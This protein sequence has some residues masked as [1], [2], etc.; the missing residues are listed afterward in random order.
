MKRIWQHPDE[1]TTGKRYWRSLNQLAERPG[2]LEARVRE[3]PDGVEALKDE[4]EAETSRRNF[5]KLMGAS[6]ALAGL[7]ACRRPEFA[8]KP[9]A[10][11]P[12]WVIPGKVLFYAT[13]MPRA[14]SGTP[15]VVHTFEGR[16]T[17]L[18]GN[19]LHPDSNGG[20]DIQAQAS[21][22]NL[23]DPNRAQSFQKAG[24]KADREEFYKFLDAKK[25]EL[26]AKQGG[27][28]A[29]L[30]DEAVT[31]T[32]QRLLGE[33][34]KKHPQ[35]KIYR[36]ETFG[37][38]NVRVAY[39]TAF[40]AGAAP[41]YDLSKADRVFSLD[42]DF[43]GQ[44]RIGN[45]ATGQFMVRRKADAPEDGPKMNRLYVAEGRFTVTGGMADHR[46]RVHTSQ[47]LKAA[48]RLGIAVAELT[49][50]AG[51]KA[52]AEAVKLAGSYQ[53]HAR[54]DKADF[55]SAFF[56]EAAK[57]LVEKKGAS[58]VLAGSQQDA[59]VHLLAIAINQA[60]GAFGTVIQ[61]RQTGSLVAGTLDELAASAA[62]KQIDTL[63]VIG[64]TDPVF[65]A[66]PDIV[67]G[68]L[69]AALKAVPNVIV[70]TTRPKTITAAS[71]SWVVPATHYLEQWGDTRGSEGSLAVVQ[72]MIAPLYSGVLSDVEL[73]LAVLS[74]APL[75]GQPAPAPSGPG[76]P[77][78]TGFAFK[79]VRATFDAIVKDPSESKWN[80]ALRDGFAAGSAYPSASAAAAS[81]QAIGAALAQAK[82]VDIGEGLEITFVPC[83]KIHDGRYINNGWL[84]EAPDSM[85][86][87]TWDN[88]AIVSVKTGKAL[89]I[90][91]FTEDSA[92]V[93]SVEVNGLKRYYPVLMIPGHADNSVTIATGYGQASAGRVGKGTGFDAYALRSAATPY[94]AM[95]A[96]TAV[97][98]I[99]E[100][101]SGS[102]AMKGI[103]GREEIP[104]VYPLG[105]TEEHHTMYGRALVREGTVED[106]QKDKDFVMQQGTD[107]HLHGDRE[108]KNAE[109]SYSFYKPA[110]GNDENGK[111]IELLNDT[112]HQWGMVIDLNK[113]TGCT[114]CTI[115]CQS[116]NNIPIVGKDQVI[117]GRE[118][119]WIRMDRYF[120]TDLDSDAAQNG[121]K[122]EKE[123]WNEDN[124]DEPEMLVQPVG[125]Q[126]CEA[127]PCESVCP[128]NA[129]VHTP[130]GL[131]S[132][133]YNRCIGTRYCANNCPFKARRFNFFDYNKRNPLVEN[134]FL[135]IKHNSLYSGPFGQRQDTEL[136]KLQKNPNV[137][138]RMRGV[139]EKC[140]YCLQRI[141]SARVE[142]RAQGRRRRRLETGHSDEKLVIEDKDIRIPTDGIKTACQEAC[143]AEAI[144]FGNRLDKDSAVE[145]W[146][147][148]SRNY[149]LLGYLN[150]RART[151]YLGRIKNPNL[152]LLALSKLEKEKVGQGSKTRHVHVQTE[153]AA[154]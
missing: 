19:K 145:K 61:I 64:E 98:K 99:T 63:V 96:P 48:V 94:F 76:Q 42:C 70:H 16:P 101:V 118:M 47:T 72:P 33:L 82:D 148:N 105:R 129:T 30:I 22:L 123:A 40:E 37:Q 139:I 74:D 59:A 95:V 111:P 132:M 130:D 146:R 18:Q 10:K 17:H 3:F 54:S 25:A 103:E 116:E 39:A 38:A 127:A 80:N 15:M 75:A 89:G 55:Y 151:T 5:I 13:A 35:A 68:G 114:A 81:M 83:S 85:S 50:D 100:K 45:N 133:V 154:H 109:N 62:G 51:L 21:V 93:I 36:H 122:V 49:G 14:V 27:G 31:P 4:A 117:R 141:E 91:P 6:T 108:A 144:A 88:V 28:L 24:V 126:H 120:A 8:I 143:P 84:Q 110:A 113:C 150:V 1:K 131:N 66:P 60:L 138:I 78:D 87:V 153:G 79:A 134:S 147:K 142:A 102:D 69:S 121:R 53:G 46:L 97:R 43:M 149:E 137:S 128:V 140:T 67:A 77:E 26:A 106:W 71:S 115:A 34:V 125:C 90:N 11:A 136:S 20:L 29:I 135:G 52:A 124:M 41:A 92:E 12:E 58:V 86:K 73:L 57:D 56:K 44:D 9:Y 104:V 119:H 152:A 107:G 23:Y 32:R 112:L 7:A 2:T 65:E